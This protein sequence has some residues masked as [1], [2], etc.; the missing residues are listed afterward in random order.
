VRSETLDRRSAGCFGL[1]QA[2]RPSAIGGTPAFERDD[3]VI[4]GGGKPEQLR[5]DAHRIRLV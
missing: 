4:D 3:R 2:S 5:L 1:L